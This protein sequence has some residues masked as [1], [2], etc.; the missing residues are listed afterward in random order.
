MLFDRIDNLL[1]NACPPESLTR[2]RTA[3]WLYY[4]QGFTAKEIAGMP[5]MNLTVKGVE[6]LL[7]RLTAVLR[8]RLAPP[9]Q[10]GFP[11]AARPIVTEE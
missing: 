6:S 8:A 11:P 7:F 9:D 2:D 3:F 5:A 4:R 10:K 1:A